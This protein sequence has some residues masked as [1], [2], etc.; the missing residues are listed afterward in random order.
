MCAKPVPP[1]VPPAPES[2]HSGL[3]PAGNALASAQS[4]YEP[5]GPQAYRSEPDNW[6]ENRPFPSG[7]LA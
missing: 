5:D 4:A 2:K 3:P 7:G 1:R 6:K